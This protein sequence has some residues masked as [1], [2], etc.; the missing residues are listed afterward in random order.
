MSPRFASYWHY[1]GAASTKFITPTDK[2]ARSGTIGAGFSGYKRVA[3][4]TSVDTDTIEK[5]DPDLSIEE[6]EK[7]GAFYSLLHLS[8]NKNVWSDSTYD[9]FSISLDMTDNIQ[10]QMRDA[11]LR[12]LGSYR[13]F[14]GVF[15][16]YDSFFGGQSFS[17]GS[18]YADFSFRMKCAPTF[19]RRGANVWEQH[20][21]GF[22]FYELSEPG[23]LTVFLPLCIR[24]GISLTGRLTIEGMPGLDWVTE[25]FKL[26]A[27][28]VCYPMA[29]GFNNIGESRALTWGKSSVEL[30]P[31]SCKPGTYDIDSRIL[32]TQVDSSITQKSKIYFVVCRLSINPYD[33]ITAYHELYQG[34]TPYCGYAAY[35]TYV[36]GRYFQRNDGVSSKDVSCP[37]Q[38]K[39][40][41]SLD[42]E[43][44]MSPPR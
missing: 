19:N 35:P 28:V 1:V 38:I 40:R 15:L 29:V 4:A 12:M 30:G 9:D 16:T 5:W 8:A 17:G 23:H 7:N 13:D 43:M 42:C 10:T 32:L 36:T 44:K 34:A 11:M 2:H 18:L 3:R 39:A 22:E 14:V 24:K 33:A 6:D 20:S 31:F 25:Q 21:A 41:L 37:V 26:Y 27:T